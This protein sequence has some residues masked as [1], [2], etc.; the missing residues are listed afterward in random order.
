[1]LAVA[2]DLWNAA[3]L[4]DNQVVASAVLAASPRSH[5]GHWLLHPIIAE[6]QDIKQA[7]SY[8]VIKIGRQ[9]NKI[10]DALAKRAT[11]PTSCFF[12][13][14]ALAH[15]PTCNIKRVL[16]T[17]V[18]G[19]MIPISV[20]CLCNE[21]FKFSKKPSLMPYGFYHV[22]CAPCKKLMPSARNGEWLKVDKE[23]L[24]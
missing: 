19:N 15:S 23:P 18:W 1:M 12:S 22:H 17:F 20:T 11:I 3:L 6:V 14:Q 24:S 7:K 21:S 16:E 9:T 13:C 2:L 5:P 8:S 4:T 10:A